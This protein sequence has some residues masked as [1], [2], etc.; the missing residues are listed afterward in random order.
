MWRVIH[1]SSGLD[2]KVRELPEAKRIAR[3]YEGAQILDC[4]GCVRY[5]TRAGRVH[6]Q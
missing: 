2:R 3:N 6:K 5:Y 4:Y 1:G